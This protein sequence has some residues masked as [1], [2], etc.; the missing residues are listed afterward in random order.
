MDGLSWKTLLKWMIWGY[1][2]FRKHLYDIFNFKYSIIVI[3]YQ[4]CLQKKMEQTILMAA[5][6]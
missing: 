2:Y 5:F 3:V 6:P 1:P 4:R